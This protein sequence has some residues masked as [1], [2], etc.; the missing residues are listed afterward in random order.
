MKSYKILGP[1]KFS[2]EER[3]LSPLFD[4]DV[5]IKVTNI[6]LCGSD[7]HLYKGDY[8]GPS[9]Y[10]ILFGHEWAGIVMDIGASVKGFKI[11]DKVTGDCSMYCG[12]C[13]M[14][15]TDRNLCLFIEK[16]GITIDGASAEY[17]VRDHKY[18]YKAGP[19]MDLALLSLTEPL[20]VA[21]HL[22]E[23]IVAL[24]G[25][26]ADKK[27]LICGGGPIGQSILLVLTDLFGCTNIEMLEISQSR[28]N[29]GLLHGAKKALI[30]DSDLSEKKDYSSLYQKAVYNIII[31]TTGSADVFANAFTLLKPRGVLGCLGMISKS[32]IPQSQIVS[33]SL[34]V[35][36]TI[37]GTGEFGD[38]IQYI[39]SH[40]E[41]V[42]RLISH[43][44]QMHE[45]D[46]AFL[47]AT[48]NPQ[49]MKVNLKF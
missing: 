21:K 48:S 33:K 3:D 26:L 29:L 1:R 40:K 41:K 32:E 13:E 38:V 47:T 22:I 46:E 14:C 11:G 44:Y 8:S 27:I 49:T 4:Q 45:L 43:Y 12:K 31:E 16:Y 39:G 24:T 2:I 25:D 37:G 30:A 19:E 36:G 42:S 17:I 28:L 18:L 5:L 7:L 6:G 20:A 9:R 10:P 34:L 15:A 23:R 35:I